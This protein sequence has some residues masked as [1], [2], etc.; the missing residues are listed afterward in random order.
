MSSALQPSV[1]DAKAN[2][3]SSIANDAELAKAAPE[4]R[5]PSQ[6]Q[7][8]SFREHSLRI[9]TFIRPE[10]YLL[11]TIGLLFAYL[12]NTGITTVVFKTSF[13]QAGWHLFIGFIQ[14]FTV[15]AAWRAYRSA[16]GQSTKPSNVLIGL[17]VLLPI[18]VV[19]LFTAGLLKVQWKPAY[20]DK[21][22]YLVAALVLGAGGFTAKALPKEGRAKGILGLGVFMAK[23]VLRFARDWLPFIALLSTYE[24]AL[25]LVGRVRSTLYDPEMFLLDELIFRGHLDVWFQKIVSAKLTEAFAFFYNGLYL[26]PIVVGMTLY[27]QWRHREFR[28]FLLAFIVAGWVGYLGYLLV[29]VIGP[30]YFYPELYSVPL[31]AT[32]VTDSLRE[33]AMQTASEAGMRFLALAEQVSDRAAY[34]GQYPRN[35]FPSLH[36][37]WGV[38]V[39][40]CSYRYTRPLFYILAIPLLWMIAATSYLRFHYMVDVLAGVL[41]AVLM[42]TLMPRLDHAW[43][44]LHARVRGLPKP[45]SITPPAR[46]FW[47]KARLYSALASFG[48]FS[49]F[50]AAYVFRSDLAR[51]KVA[52]A[53]AVSREGAAL[54]QLA[55]EEVVGARFGDS[56]ELLGVRTESN[57]WAQDKL[58]QVELHFRALAKT[59]GNWKV[60]VHVRDA[61]GRNLT[62]ADHHP[63][64]GAYRIKEW[65]PGDIVKDTIT[66]RV[67]KGMRG[68]Q[69]G[70]WVGLFDE[71]KVEQ[72]MPVTLSPP[73]HAVSGHAV[74]VLEAR[75]N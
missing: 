48:L 16:V 21:G 46:T 69:L 50:V 36:T 43:E 11:V 59:E 65:K 3:A 56:I 14:V 53:E 19:G 62:N 37:A 10:E 26:F 4:A 17:V 30:R 39:L 2:D 20:L 72:R 9:A 49:A 45:P 68:S 6:Q 34:G 22:W 35:C 40:I 51:E 29:P 64:G 23:D 5:P 13:I 31:Y 63:V 12:H 33:T 1:T 57:R 54:P 7:K 32:K 8:A 74:K 25:R 38:V 58:V 24:N 41:L 67:P 55:A 42:V 61:R 75:V 44:S 15:V 70:I 27:L 73:R 60:F 18:I 52:L 47:E 71:Y 66:L 28:A